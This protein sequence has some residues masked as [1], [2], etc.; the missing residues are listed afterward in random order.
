[1]NFKARFFGAGLHLGISVVIAA[2]AWLVISRF[3]YPYPFIEISGGR[4]LFLL[5][6]VVDVVLGPLLTFAVLS[7][8]K[9]RQVLRRDLMAIGTVQLAA[10]IY[11]LG[12]MYVARPIYLVHEVDRFKVVSAADIDEADLAEA[13]PEFRRLPFVGVETIG[14]REARNSAE[15][16]SSLGLE[17]AGKDLAMQPGWWQPLSSDNRA[18]IRQR[19]KSIAL[20]RQRATDGGAG[21][22]RILSASGVRDEDAIALPLVTRTVSWSVLL[23]KR[24]LRILGYLPVD[25]F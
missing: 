21:L 2:L 16:L 25:L 7:P 12:I 20:L 11:G 10:L 15:K 14:L 13:A 22:D 4:Q 18:S 8:G 9:V 19:G 3:F 6:V 5:I 23:D 1:M 24:D 17:I